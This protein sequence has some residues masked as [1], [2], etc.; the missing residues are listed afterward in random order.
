[1]LFAEVLEDEEP[2]LAA[3]RASMSTDATATL[4]RVQSASWPSGPNTVSS[5]CA[6]SIQSM[7]TG[8][9]CVTGW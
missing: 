6:E 9:R 3:T 4:K 7:T 8:S 5:H 2:Q 1:M